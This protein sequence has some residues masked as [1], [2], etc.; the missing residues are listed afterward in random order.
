MPG[1][2]EKAKKAYAKAKTIKSL[3]KKHN[4]ADTKK[5]KKTLGIWGIGKKMIID[6]GPE[7]A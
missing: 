7:Y 5:K 1:P 3:T 6:H 2:T 4:I